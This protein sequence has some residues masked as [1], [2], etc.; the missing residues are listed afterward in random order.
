M[1][2]LDAWSRSGSFRV[3]RVPV[4]GRVSCCRDSRPCAK[5]RVG[6]LCRRGRGAGR[7]V[8]PG[9]PLAPLAPLRYLGR[10]CR[11]GG[12]SAEAP[13]LSCQH[14]AWEALARAAW[15]RDLLPN[16]PARRSALGEAPATHMLTVWPRTS[17]DDVPRT[18]LL[19]PPL[20]ARSLKLRSPPPPRPSASARVGNCDPGVHKASVKP[21]RAPVMITPTCQKPCFP[22]GLGEC[23]HSCFLC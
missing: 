1:F 17:R 12:R 22:L 21:G 14:S 20:S 19:L 2:V 4:A 3:W 6:R 8:S 5:R 11:G 15:E 23:R 7:R 10:R 18:H 13:R 9:Q 16:P